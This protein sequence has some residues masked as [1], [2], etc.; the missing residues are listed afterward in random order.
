MLI[1]II[2]TDCT[3]FT[4]CLKWIFICIEKLWYVKIIKN[5]DKARWGK[6]RQDKERWGITWTKMCPLVLKDTVNAPYNIQWD[7]IDA[8]DWRQFSWIIIK[9]I[10]SI[11]SIEFWECNCICNSTFQRDYTIDHLAP[12]RCNCNLKKKSNSLYRIINGTLAVKLSPHKYHRSPLMQNWHWVRDWLGSVR[13][14]PLSEPMF[15]YTYVA[16]SQKEHR[17]TTF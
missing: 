17:L 10:Y 7:L 2:N 15:T 3:S 6:I 9:T 13:Y 8:N 12:S 1:P 14:K 5:Q 4:H 16:I 11:S